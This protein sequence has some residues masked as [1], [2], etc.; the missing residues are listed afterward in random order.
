MCI[1]DCTCSATRQRSEVPHAKKARTPRGSA[2]NGV[3]RRWRGG[4]SD[5]LCGLR[6]RCESDGRQHHDGERAAG[7][8]GE[9]A[10][11]CFGS[12]NFGVGWSG[13]ASCASSDDLGGLQQ[14]GDRQRRHDGEGCEQGD[15][16]GHLSCSGGSCLMSGEMPA[17]IRLDAGRAIDFHHVQMNAAQAALKSYGVSAAQSGQSPLSAQ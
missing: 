11:H 5:D 17:L 15:G 3:A 4:L 14:R 16:L 7:D 9:H 6:K 8:F 1:A 12:V 13:R 10:G 2:P